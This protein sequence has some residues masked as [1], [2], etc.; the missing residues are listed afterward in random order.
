MGAGAGAG[1]D[2]DARAVEV[3]SRSKDA[4]PLCWKYNRTAGRQQH[5]SGYTA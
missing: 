4:S 1:A 3:S 5:L 2:V